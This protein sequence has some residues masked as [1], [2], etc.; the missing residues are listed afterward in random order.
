M[1]DVDIAVAHRAA[2]FRSLMAGF[3]SGVTVVTTVDADGGPLGLTCSSLSAV[4]AKPPLLLVC[5]D[6]RSST[7]KALRDHG[8]FAVN[9]LHRDGREAARIFAAGGADRF[10]SVRWTP[11]AGARLPRL[12]LDA[13]SVAEC[14]VHTLQPAGDH[15]VV[16][17]EVRA[18]EHLT[19]TAPLMY[20]LRQYAVWPGGPAD[21]KED[22]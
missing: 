21:R 16:I 14:R 9:L 4:S 7:L 11:T 22:R 20:G 19:P 17:G 13:R 3:P 5:I 10:R 18:V 12:D 2:E 15:T 8:Q 1:K 6:N